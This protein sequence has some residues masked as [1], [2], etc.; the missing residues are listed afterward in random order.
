MNELEQ[1][2]S[3]RRELKTKG[4]GRRAGGARAT[5]GVR[6]AATRERAAM[7]EAWRQRESARRIRDELTPKTHIEKPALEYFR[8][9]YLPLGLP[10]PRISE[11]GL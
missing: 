7:D 8:D 2:Q 5:R 11:A 3:G 9:E 4:P 6:C 1:W 10:V